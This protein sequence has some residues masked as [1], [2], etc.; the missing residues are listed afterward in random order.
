MAWVD[1]SCIRRSTRIASRATPAVYTAS[2][3]DEGGPTASPDAENSS[4]DDE[5]AVVSQ[6]RP[7]TGRGTKKIIKHMF[8]S[9]KLHH[10]SQRYKL[11][12]YP[13]PDIPSKQKAVMAVLFHELD[14]PDSTI[15]DKIRYHQYCGAWCE[16]VQW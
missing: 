1:N 3:D 8:I 15:E 11:A 12:V 7:V 2:S 4:P 14:H 16:F 13:H 10:V 5:D 9:Q 6:N